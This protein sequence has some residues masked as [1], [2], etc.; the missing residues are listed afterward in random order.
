MIRLYE[1]L[2]YQQTYS[3][4]SRGGYEV[5]GH[6]AINCKLPLKTSGSLSEL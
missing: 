6:V 1:T 2:S 3:R 4:D 5:T